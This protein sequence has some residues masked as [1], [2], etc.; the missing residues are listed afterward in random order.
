MGLDTARS[1]VRQGLSFLEPQD[2]DKN[3]ACDLLV[4][5]YHMGKKGMIATVL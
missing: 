3:T 1:A 2:L 5:N 4:F